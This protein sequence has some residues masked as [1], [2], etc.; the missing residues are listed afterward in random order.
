MIRVLESALGGYAARG[1][2]IARLAEKI[3]TQTTG[4]DLAAN[5]VGIMVNQRAAEANLVVA[6]VANETG[7][8]L[9]HVIA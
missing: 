1:A 8:S 6:R 4:E 7:E 3:R 2:D 9:L 5:L